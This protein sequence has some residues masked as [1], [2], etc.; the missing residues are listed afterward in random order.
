V[1]SASQQTGFWSQYLGPCAQ[2][3]QDCAP[4]LLAQSCQQP[5]QLAA[6]L[7]DA[8]CPLL[9]RNCRRLSP[10]LC[11]QRSESQSVMFALSRPV[12]RHHATPITTPEPCAA[13]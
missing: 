8:E 2:V 3:R 13:K 12:F 9:G 11:S 1:A 4:R 6:V 10:R 7:R 5:L